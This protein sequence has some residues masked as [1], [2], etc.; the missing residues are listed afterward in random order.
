MSN[1]V[2]LALYTAA[3]AISARIINSPIGAVGGGLFGFTAEITLLSLDGVI[4]IYPTDTDMSKT[5]KYIVSLSISIIAGWKLLSLCGLDVSLKEVLKV[6]GASLVT[7][8][9][10]SLVIITTIRVAANILGPRLE[11]ST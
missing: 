10:L 9:V 3:S 4:R 8:P 11:E 6:T 1:F 2:D 7:L 5:A